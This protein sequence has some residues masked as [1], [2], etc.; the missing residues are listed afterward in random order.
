MEHGENF[1]KLL[2]DSWGRRGWGSVPEPGLIGAAPPTVPTPFTLG[3]NPE[4]KDKNYLLLSVIVVIVWYKLYSKTFVTLSVEYKTIKM[5]KNLDQRQ[6]PIF[7]YSVPNCHIL[8]IVPIPLIWSTNSKIWHDL[9][10]L[11][12]LSDRTRLIQYGIGNGALYLGMLVWC[13]VA[14]R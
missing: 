9:V 1:I 3:S 4:I 6:K 13:G 11:P 12:I 8:L 14:W 10:Q 2:T 7:R 5:S